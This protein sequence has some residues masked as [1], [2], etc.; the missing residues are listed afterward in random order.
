MEERTGPPM[1]PNRT[2]SAFFAAVSA[3]SVNGSPVASMEHCFPPQRLRRLE[4]LITHTP[5][6]RWS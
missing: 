4:A 1:A 6:S 3:S 5:P 2:A